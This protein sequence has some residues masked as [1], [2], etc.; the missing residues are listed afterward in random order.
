MKL[1]GQQRQ[2]IEEALLSAFPDR[3]SLAQMVRHG[4]NENLA[5]ISDGANLREVIFGLLNWAD[6][7]GRMDQVLAAA[8]AANPANPALQAMATGLGLPPLVAGAAGLSPD[9]PA[10]PYPGM[11]PFRAEDA[12]FF[13]GR[14]D[15]LKQMVRHL[16]TSN[17]LL[18]LGPSGSGK[19][20][21]VQAGLIPA[22]R[23][24]PYWSPGTW[25]IMPMRPGSTPLT[26]LGSELGG[27]PSQAAPT[28]AAWLAAHAPA[29]RLLLVIDQF[30]EIYTQATPAGQATF[31]AAIL[32]LRA[33]ET[34]AVVL[35]LRT[36]FF[37]DLMTGDLW[38]VGPGERQEIA[39]LRGLALAEA[40]RQP[41]L[42]VGVEVEP[43]LIE[44]LLA[45]AANEPGA[46]PLLQ[47]TLVL[48]WG[49]MRD[50][51]LT[52]A[53]YQ[54]LGSGNRSGLAV[55]LATRADTTLSALPLPDQVLARRIF[56]RLVQ[57]GTGRPD[58]RRQQTEAELCADGDD[59]AQFDHVLEYLADHRLLTLSTDLRTG[60]RCVDIAHEALIAG[61]PL[62]SEWLL[63]RRASE[64][65]RRRLEDKATEWVRLGRGTG[66]LLDAIQLQEAETWLHGSE[67]Q[68]LGAS[69]DLLAL[70]AASRTAYEQAQQEK[71]A[72]QRLGEE[73]KTAAALA[74]QA[75]ESAQQAGA[76]A[77]TAAQAEAVAQQQARQAEEIARQSQGRSRRRAQLLVALLV[78]LGLGAAFVLI[79]P[80][81]LAAQAA[82][83]L[84]PLSGGA[85]Q[86]GSAADAGAADAPPWVATVA[87]FQLEQYE[88][89]NRQYGLCKDAGSCTDP[90]DPAALHVPQRQDLPVTGVTAPQAAAYC[91][92]LGRR[93]PTEIE[94]ELAARG[95]QAND[96]PWPWGTDPLTATRANL[97]FP[98][99]SEQGIDLQPVMS[100]PRGISPEKVYNLVGN[101]S[102]WT[103]SFYTA[104]Y[105]GYDPAHAAWNGQD[106]L[107]DRALV[108]RGDSWGDSIF[109]FSRVSLREPQPGNRPAPWLG[110][111]CAAN[112]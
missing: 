107:N 42:D 44:R 35:T 13:Y 30:E 86:M 3:A 91:R 12:R 76:R 55:A 65:T 56:L 93:L 103:T 62:L 43:A 80:R 106:L 51:R 39:P 18:V 75:Q 6:A 101:A 63:A 4:L 92:W 45:D 20:S 29:T 94:W 109:D 50:R 32:A 41:A 74:A 26:A 14:E 7:Q 81:V 1:D 37:S 48:L 8:R 57:F 33:V 10:C 9:L 53:A 22:L 27:D 24:S 36:D 71:A 73:V 95:L 68:D 25:G 64:Q 82:G 66:G 40:I 87:P 58:T 38:P 46:L 60:D 5:T 70:V 105:T 79:Y 112:R 99:L 67:S 72:A 77:V 110:F 19:S 102:E 78:L 104:S 21:L 15:E 108:T 11:V 28:V 54:A 84:V 31:I 97:I 100:Y 16:R 98:D 2:Q 23:S 17:F 61:W 47:E 111:R 89:S 90:A 49:E 52:L 69:T 96:Q 59:P 83:P 88:V 85:V 34:C